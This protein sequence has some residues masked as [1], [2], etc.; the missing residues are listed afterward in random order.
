MARARNIKPGFF[1]NEGLVELDYGTRLLF[2]GLWTISD[3]EGRLEDRPKRIKMELFPGDDL[4]VDKSLDALHKAGFIL[5]YE[6]DGARY[7]QVLAFS[8]HQNPHHKEPP[9]TIPKPGANPRLSVDAMTPKSETSG[10]SCCDQN[11]GQAQGKPE[12][13][14]GLASVEPSSD[15]A[16]SLIPDSGFLIPDST[17]PL[18]PLADAKGES[19]PAKSDDLFGKPPAKRERKRKALSDCPDEFD[20]S[21]AMYDWANARGI[22]D[23]EVVFETER[24]LNHH[25]AKGTRHADWQATWRTWMLNVVR[26]RKES[27]HR[28]A[29]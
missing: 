3:R 5:R 28:R 8:K 23:D 16:D 15:P 20:I 22:T 21:D 10:A 14:P 24:C 1:K 19:P 25:K 2:I 11:L 4:N 7:I 18:T 9:S 12:T 13:V 17:P 29:S 6:V 27:Q 26:F